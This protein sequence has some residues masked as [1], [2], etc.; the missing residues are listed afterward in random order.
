MR[1]PIYIEVPG[2]PISKKRPKFARVGKGVKT[3]N[4][5]ETDEGRFLISVFTQ[6]GEI[7][8]IKG[9]I[10]LDL[11]F[12]MSRPKSHYGTGRNSNTLK[13]S[14]PKYHIVKPD[15][16][17]LEKFAMDALNGYLWKDDCQVVQ[18]KVDKKYHEPGDVF[19]PR[20]LI[21]VYTIEGV[22]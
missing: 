12:I 21:K 19:G 6:V 4:P 13:K 11:T 8:P 2:N 10:R 3:Y 9:A 18:G 20:T 14:A 5:S 15:R 1:K 16:D 22:L 17:N 7:E